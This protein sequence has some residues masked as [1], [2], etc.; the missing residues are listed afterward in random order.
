MGCAIFV[1]LFVWL[2]FGSDIKDWLPPTTRQINHATEA[3]ESLSLNRDKIQR[4]DV[5]SLPEGW[6]ERVYLQPEKIDAV[7]DYFVGLNLSSDFPENPN[8]Y[9]GM[10]IVA[11]FAFE[12]GSEVE[13]NH[14]GNMFLGVR[15]NNAIIWLRMS[16]Y[17]ASALD[18]LLQGMPS[19]KEHE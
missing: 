8:E 5:Y 17:E 9:A 2:V 15:V 7:V 12:D 10:S 11:V 16:Y 14:F 18:S 19:D 13:L 1:T 3:L 6:I 4:V